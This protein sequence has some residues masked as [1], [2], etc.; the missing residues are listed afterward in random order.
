[1]RI[2]ESRRLTGPGFVC[3]GPAVALEALWDPGDDP[4]ARIAAWGERVAAAFAALDLGPP[5]LHVRPYGRGATLAFAFPPDR[6]YAGTEI[7]EWAA[8]DAPLAGA[9]PALRAALEA[10][11]KPALLA[12][13]DEAAARGVPVLLDDDALTLGQG[14]HAATFPLSSLPTDVAWGERRRVPVVLVTGTNGKSTTTRLL[15]RCIEAAGLVV[16]TSST[17]EIRVA[18]EV[19]ETGDWTGPGAARR[20]LR[21]PRVQAAVLET[22]RGGILRRGLGVDR[23]DVA[24]I[25]NVAADHL[26]DW[27]VD[28]V[29][30]LARAKGVVARVVPPGGA[31]VLNAEDPNLRA[32]ALLLPARVVWFSPDEAALPPGWGEAVTVRGGA[33]SHLAVGVETPVLPIADVPITFGGAARFNVENALAATAAALALGLLPRHVAAGLRAL[34]PTAEHNPAR[35][36]VV[37]VDGVAVVLDFGHNPHGLDAL[38]RFVTAWRPAGRRTALITQAGDRDDAAISEL[39]TTLARHGV[40]HAVVRPPDP[41][42]LRGRTP[43][44]LEALLTGAF[45]AAGLPRDAVTAA[46]TELASLQAALAASAPGDTVLLLV[47]VDRDE[48]AAW[49]ATRGATPITS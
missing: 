10:E 35:L 29:A 16:G 14:E 23:A 47:H 31:V 39:A 8:G 18:R 22:A 28:D 38:M 17:D 27:G 7:N 20:V 45:V 32:L 6:L 5:S 43:A 19:L 34:R 33:I 37:D 44:A 11:A 36:N 9:L 21:D 2:D 42:H 40:T 30:T 46:P 3:D 4:G 48:V 1:M 24:V 26:G 15:A 13:L 25:T 12:L 41:H 49:L